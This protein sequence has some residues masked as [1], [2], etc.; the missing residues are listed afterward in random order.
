[1]I[2]NARPTAENFMSKDVKRIML[3]FRLLHEISRNPSYSYGLVD[4][5]CKTAVA[6][7]FFGKSRE[8]IKND[9]YNTI[10]ALEK[11]GY[12]KSARKIE[13]GKLKNYYHITPLGKETLRKSKA[14][15]LKS[16]REL[17]EIVS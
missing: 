12:I 15:F 13:D 17:D 8:D 7:K 3:K 6:S 1:M 10:N 11:S 16:V 9:I 2:A 14:F 4:V 5:L